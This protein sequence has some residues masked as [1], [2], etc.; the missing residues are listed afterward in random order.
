M[1]LIPLTLTMRASGVNAGAPEEGA[2]SAYP[3]SCDL[4]A[5]Q[6]ACTCGMHVGRLG[7]ALATHSCDRRQK[8]DRPLTQW[9]PK[10]S[11]SDSGNIMS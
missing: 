5:A 6:K 9:Q 11:G 2:Q 8:I 4:Q 10:K 1:G 3:V 7:Y